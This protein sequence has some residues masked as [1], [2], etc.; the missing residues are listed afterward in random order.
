MRG[1]E[2]RSNAV[3]WQQVKH[4]FVRH[5]TGKWTARLKEIK[6]SIGGIS[7]RMLTLSLRDLERDGLVTRPGTPSS[8]CAWIT[9]PPRPA[10]RCANP[11]VPSALGR[12]GHRDEVEDTR[13]RFDAPLAATFRRV[14]VRPLFQ[15]RAVPL[16]IRRRERNAEFRESASRCEEYVF[17]D[18]PRARRADRCGRFEPQFARNL[19]GAVGAD[20]EAIER[21][22][23]SRLDLRERSE[24]SIV[25]ALIERPLDPDPDRRYVIE[26]DDGA[27]SMTPRRRCED[28]N[29]NRIAMRPGVEFVERGLRPA[30]AEFARGRIDGGREIYSTEELEAMIGPSFR[31]RSRGLENVGRVR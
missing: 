17:F 13:S 24:R 30:H 1:A 25:Q 27:A 31:I 28:L 19:V 4:P 21:Q 6:R 18:E 8:R 9:S 7:Q 2:L 11:S 3:Y 15:Y 5:G 23:V 22:H 10:A 26:A 12:S 29:E 14:E 20:A 16:D